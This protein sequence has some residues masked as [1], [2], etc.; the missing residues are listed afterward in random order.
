MN[1]EN[2]NIITGF[3]SF[4]R[5]KPLHYNADRKENPEIGNIRF[6][7]VV[8]DGGEPFLRITDK[9]GK[10]Y[11]NEPLGLNGTDG[12]IATEFMRSEAGDGFNIK[13]TE[14]SDRDNELSLWEHPQLAGLLIGSSRIVDE[15]LSPVEVY[16]DTF[17]LRLTFEYGVDDTLNPALS[18][19]DADSNEFAPVV[20]LTDSMILVGNRIC[21]VNSV[22]E[23][24]RNITML[25]SPIP[26]HLLEQYLSVFFSYVDHVEVEYCGMPAHFSKSTETMVPTLVLEKVASDK[27]LYMR[28]TQTAEGIGEGPGSQILLTRVATVSEDNRIQVRSVEMIDVE[29][30]IEHLREMIHKSAPTRQDVR[31]IYED[32]GLFIVPS[33]TAGPFLLKYLHTVLKEFRLIGSEKLREYKVSAAVPKLKLNLSSGIDFLEGEADIEIGDERFTL[34]DILAQFNKKRY[35]EL[36]DGNKAIIDEKYMKKLQRI[37]RLKGKDGKVK[38]T[39]FDL[40]EVE[41][42][43]DDRLK[44]D[45]AVKARSVY[46]GFNTLKEET[47]VLPDI[48]ATLRGYQ[49]EGVKWLKYL[50]DNNLGG[51]LADDMG[52]GKTIQTISL[53]SLVMKENVAPA[54]VIMPR[55]LLFNWENEISKFNPGLRVSTYYGPD[56]NFG[57]SMKSQVVLTTYAI[58]RN[59]IEK[60]KDK[61]FSLIVLDESQNIKNLAAQTTQAVTILRSSHRF[62]LSGTPMENNL[63]EL[64]SLFRFLNP[65]M[66]GTL[67]DFNSNYTY[68]IQ[69][70]GDK[71]ATDALRR[72][73][74]PFM[75]RRLKKDV[76]KELPERIEQVYYVE[77]DSAQAS[78]YERRRKE[79]LE[80]IRDTIGR[81]G[82]QKSQFVMFQA[83]NELRRIA[84]VPESLTESRIKSPK[85]E[86]LVDSVGSAVENGHK[87]V[88][89]FNF[90]AGLEIVGSRLSELGVDF[91][92]MTGS[93]STPARKKAVDRFQT[94]SE[95]KAMLMTLKVGGV[96]LNLTAADTV[97]IFEPWWNKAAEEQGIN[98]L[99]RIGQ[100][101]TVYS[102]SIIAKNT[103][104]EKILQ[105]QEQKKELFDG[106]IG[107]DGA[108]AKHLS[109]EDI[110]FILS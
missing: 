11:E 8:A 36:S 100:K 53:L 83:L 5:L 61:E 41:R 45:Y 52:L 24:F 10:P 23:N 57:E 50:Y 69:K 65:G 22:G 101:N 29:S 7:I 58:V 89:F 55:S 66:F 49:R 30:H 82:V 68:P 48:K 64:Y 47:L 4:S 97:F 104:E 99:H 93:T 88:V 16:E 60:F 63:T 76:L 102:Y 13:W 37:F 78:F 15:H 74:F 81:E 86:Q 90:V 103:I 9:E 38:V 19:V 73:I 87:V 17:K 3:E 14:T 27:A 54:L 79:Y 25:I 98:R 21:H 39:F 59:D 2:S 109:E 62:A 91:E 20:F 56:R 46:E 84:S 108:S 28:V 32:D 94:D 1:L 80:Q 6:M 31:D 67:E 70:N 33:V 75:L 51:C 85:I 40:P 95:C 77:M 106:L 12:I 72:K 110:E 44:Q 107:S 92:T 35:V 105:L 34:A 71:D 96:G 42:L 18:A 43:I 26:V